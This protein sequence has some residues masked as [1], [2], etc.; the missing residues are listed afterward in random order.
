MKPMIVRTICDG[1]LGEGWVDNFE[2]A[3]RYAEVLK[4][5]YRREFGEEAFVKINIQR[6]CS[7]AEPRPLYLDADGN[8]ATEQAEII[9]FNTWEEFASNPP[10]DLIQNLE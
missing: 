5:A 10:E 4:L 7:G 2:A 3:L 9:A 1:N 6:N 8:D